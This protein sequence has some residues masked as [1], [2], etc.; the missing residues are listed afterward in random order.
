MLFAWRA[1]TESKLPSLCL[2]KM[3][4]SL[5]VAMVG[6][7]VAALPAAEIHD[8]AELGNLPKI[9]ACLEK[10]PKQ[11]DTTDAKGR[12]VLGRAL[13]SGKKEVVVFVLGKGATEDISAA[14]VLGNKDKATAFL[15]EDP[16]RLDALDS[17]G[18]A[19]LHWAALYGEKPMVEWL[20]AEKADVN[21]L[22]G[23][24]FTPLHWAVMFNKQDVAEALIKN[25]A[26]T[27]LKV[28][29]FGW[30]PL[31]LAVIH[32][33]VA[34]AE[35]L[36]KAGVDPNLKDER[37]IPLLHQAVISGK[38]EMIGLLLANKCDINERDADGDTPLSEAL[39]HGNREIIE[40]LQQRGAKEK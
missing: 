38:K 6:W 18:K 11:I 5:T 2:S 16:K 37:N 23:D 26:D 25:K 15:K 17:N 3:K 7:C 9:K 21:L 20:L 27:Q 14:V 12:T 1:F 13:L 4:I 40:L 32:G 29:R 28:A 10:D 22:D 39:E 31:R 35:V 8:A 24:G 19:P 30:T 36:F 33:H 34:T